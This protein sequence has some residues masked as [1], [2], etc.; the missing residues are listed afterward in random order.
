MK[1][2]HIIALMSCLVCSVSCSNAPYSLGSATKAAGKLMPKDGPAEFAL[3][4][5]PEPKAE[6][7]DLLKLLRDA[8]R[9]KICL[10]ITSPK[11]EYIQ[12][13][14]DRTMEAAKKDEQFNGLYLIIIAE[15]I[16]AAAID[17]IIKDRGIRAHYGTFK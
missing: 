7:K 9:G 3:F 8:T 4:N 6:P 17:A 13:L 16:D 10:A 1:F 5:L 14:L 12:N 11:L 2:I 15:K